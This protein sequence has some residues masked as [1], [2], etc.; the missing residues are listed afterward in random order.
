MDKIYRTEH[1]NPQFMRNDWMNLNGIWQFEIDNG[2]SGKYRDLLNPEHVLESKI[3]VPFCPESKLS[4]IGNTDFMYAVWYRR[5]VNLT[6]EQLKDRKVR[7]HIGACDYITEVYVNDKF[8]GSH[9]GGYSEFSFD[10][11]EALKPGENIIT[12]YAEDDTRNSMYPSGKQSPLYVSHACFYTRTTG[13]WQTV[14]LEFMPEEHIKSFRFYPDSITGSVGISADFAG[15]AAF[16]AE[17]TYE[18]RKVGEINC[19]NCSGLRSFS[20]KLDEIHLWEPGHGRL[21]DIAMHFGGDTVYSYFGLRDIALEG[22][23]FMFNGKSVFQRLVLDQG[24]YPDG[25][26]TAPSDEAL[27]NDIEL[28]MAAGFNGARLHQKVFEPRFL[29]HCDKLGYMVWGEFPDWG[30]DFSNPLLIYSILPEWTEI[31]KRDINHPAIIGWCPLNE[32]WTYGPQQSRQYN[33]LLGMLYE[34]TKAIDPSRPVIDSSGSSHVKT[35][36]FD[37][38]DYEQNPK[39][40]DDKYNKIDTTGDF[41][42]PFRD[43][44]K[45]DGRMP[46][47]LS[48]YGGTGLCI[49]GGGAWSY[50]SSTKNLEE[51][52]ERYK[53]LTDALLDNPCICAMCYTQLTDVEQEQNGL[54]TYDRKPKM[55]IKRIYEINTKKAAI[56]D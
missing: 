45:Y 50:G 44:Q 2:K 51:Y 47:F 7:L 26:Y 37:L 11:T 19:D 28:S 46:V 4:G 33:D 43:Q 30:G 29:Y 13:I 42:Y 1:P 32:T 3:N 31:L 41:C 16:S 17:I 14:W 21:Y 20:A 39:N 23:K 48:E 52:Y 5:K 35:D 49:E 56:E 6:E 53:G 27:K 36:L 54:Y 24:F 40:F 9:R 8:A 10:V 18:G 34:Q 22:N 38:H 15:K 12:A 55:D 25:I